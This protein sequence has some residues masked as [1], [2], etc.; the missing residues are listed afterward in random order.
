MT[1]SD[2]FQGVSAILEARKRRELPAFREQGILTRA[3]KPLPGRRRAQMPAGAKDVAACAIAVHR[4]G[5]EFGRGRQRRP[6]AGSHPALAW[7]DPRLEA[8]L[9]PQRQLAS[10]P[11][12]RMKGAISRRSGGGSATIAGALRLERFHGSASCLELLR[13]AARQRQCSHRSRSTDFAALMD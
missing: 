9:H 7:C 4:R 10:A 1:M 8:I 13:P 11:T 6:R 3:S 12:G 2:P 5:A